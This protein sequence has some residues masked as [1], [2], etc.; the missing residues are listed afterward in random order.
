MLERFDKD[1]IQMYADCGVTSVEVALPF[2]NYFAHD[3]KELGKF[4]DGAGV[5]L[6]SVHLPFGG[7]NNMFNIADKKFSADTVKADEKLICRAAEA[8]MRI[9][10]IHPN[11]GDIPEDERE[12]QFETSVESLNKLA[13]IGRREGIVIAAEVLPGKNIGWCIPEMKRLTDNVPGLKICMD[14]NH[15]IEYPIDDFTDA[16][17]DKIATVHISDNDMVRERHWMPG[18]GKLD[19][20]HIIYLLKSINYAGPFMYEL[21]GPEFKSAGLRGIKN[22]YDKFMRDIING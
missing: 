2:I 19:W 7:E 1:I 8:G 15:I 5:E 21:G 18:D 3:W 13:D 9:A 14:V 6:W 11:T 16:F 20:E 22:N 10:V 12:E 4:A 17:S